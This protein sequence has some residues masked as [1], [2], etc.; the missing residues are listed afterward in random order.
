MGSG[1]GTQGVLQTLVRGFAVGLGPL[2]AKEPLVAPKTTS[3]DKGCRLGLGKSCNH[4][5][6]PY[7]KGTG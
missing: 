6:W 3:L 2:L 5:W 7:G 4:S 1:D